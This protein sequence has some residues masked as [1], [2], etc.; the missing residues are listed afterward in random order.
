M[1]KSSFQS[2]GGGSTDGPDKVDMSLGNVY[3]TDTTNVS[4]PCFAF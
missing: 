4:L 3:A 2:F 1:S